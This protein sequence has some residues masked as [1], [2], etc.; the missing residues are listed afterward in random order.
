MEST[1]LQE[2]FMEGLL[3]FMGSTSQVVLGE[4]PLDFKVYIIQV[5]F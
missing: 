2:S 4:A 3:E 1:T 5:E